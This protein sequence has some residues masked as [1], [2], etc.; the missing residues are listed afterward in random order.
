MKNTINLYVKQ[1]FATILNDTADI[2]WTIFICLGTLIWITGTALNY[3]ITRIV[4]TLDSYDIP[5]PEI[6]PKV[7]MI[8]TAC[9]EADAVENAVRS[10]LDSDYPNLEVILIDDRS[11]DGTGE[12]I[13]HLAENDDRVSAIHITELPEGWLGKPYALHKGVEMA[14]GKFLLLTDADV[15]FSRSTI[16]KTVAFC[17]DRNIDQ[18]GVL[19]KMVTDD[20]VL[21]ISMLTFVR[22]YGLI[23]RFWLIDNPKA[24]VFSGVGGYNLIRQSLFEKTNG[25]EWLKMDIADDVALSIMIHRAGGRNF[26]INGTDQIRVEWYR[27]FAGMVRGM[28]KGAFTTLGNFSLPINILKC[29][30]QFI[31]ELWPFF[32]IFLVTNP[33]LLALSWF[34]IILGFINAL[35]IDRWLRGQTWP[36]FFYPIGSILFTFMMLRGGFLGWIRGGIYWRGTFYPAEQLRKGRKVRVL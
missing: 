13:D 27:D 15:H 25:F 16:K 12:I 11:T 14:D 17:M 10:K 1:V 26:I 22:I 33:W 23:G 18:L 32:A 24:E 7:S 34:S 31:M 20:P 6:W 9:N 3:R 4:K 29:I 21:K 28:E 35:I 30:A 8:V 19:P 36:A 5:Y 2:T